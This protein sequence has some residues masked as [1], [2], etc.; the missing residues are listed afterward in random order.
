MRINTTT[1]DQ[2]MFG[3]IGTGGIVRNLGLVNVNI[4]GGPNTGAVA[5]RLF[6]TVANRGTIQNCSVHGTVSG[7]GYVG[8]VVGHSEYG[9]VQ[10]CFVAANVTCTRTTHSSYAGGVVGYN[11]DGIVENS[12]VTGNVM[13]NATSNSYIGG[14]V[15]WNY[16]GVVRNCYATGEV[17]GN[18][19]NT[20]DIGGIVGGNDLW[21]VQNC[22]ALNQNIDGNTGSSRRVVG[23]LS[24]GT[25]TN[26]SARSDMRM[27][28]AAQTW[29]SFV[30]PTFE[31]GASVLVN[32]TV[33]L[34]TVFAGW[35]TAIWNIPTGNLRAGGPLP[36]LNNVPGTQNPVLP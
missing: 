20:I 26:N 1:S 17:R 3:V 8:G 32:D 9:M 27:N 11:N 22:V 14:I 18:N 10:R 36:T 31:N 29:T 12:Y 6:G 13:S 21:N 2:G 7:L 28:G 23:R 25:L 19:V 15:G 16:D 5:G 34:S 35:D 30:G 4:T 33:P 24:S